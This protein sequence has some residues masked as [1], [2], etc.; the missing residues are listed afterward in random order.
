LLQ[1][2]AQEKMIAE[3]DQ[4]PMKVWSLFVENM[5]PVIRRVVAFS[6]SLPGMFI[7]VGH[8]WLNSYIHVSNSV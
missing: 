1:G 4:S 2:P 5:A 7:L 3:D 8:I 6:K